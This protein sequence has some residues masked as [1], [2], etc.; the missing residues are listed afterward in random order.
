MK[1]SIL[2]LI[3][4]MLAGASALMVIANVRAQKSLPVRKESTVSLSIL[5]IPM[6]AQTSATPAGG[7]EKTVEQTR[8]NIKVLR[9][10]PTHSW[11]R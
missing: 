7:P 2:R 9:G 11:F 5:G 10:Y 1:P 4:A 3:V 6:S 8:K